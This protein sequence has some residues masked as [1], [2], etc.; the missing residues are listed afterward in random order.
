V[1]SPR[2]LTRAADLEAVRREGKRTRTRTLEARTLAS[3][4]REVRVGIIVPRYAHSAVD[5]NRLK[6]R[7]R[8]LIRREWLAPLADGG[9][10]DV[11][12][13]AA[14]SA[15]DADFAGLRAELAKLVNRLPTE[16]R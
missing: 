9:T 10:R 8:E 1:A 7:L 14:P 2:W 12:L 5:R 13:R 4:R 6:R 11:V 15:Y 16:R 3:P